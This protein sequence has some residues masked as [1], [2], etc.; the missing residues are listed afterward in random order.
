MLAL[1]GLA[2]AGLGE[3]T[4]AGPEG[5]ILLTLAIDPQT[6]KVLYAGTLA[7]GAFKGTTGATFWTPINTGLQTSSV[8]AVIIDAQT[9]TTL[10]LANG[11]VG[12]FKSAD[13]GASWHPVNTGLT[14][15]S[16]LG[17]AVTCG[18]TSGPVTRGATSVAVRTQ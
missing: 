12:V 13:G 3:W 18:T 9:S 15:L 11:G 10:Y 1:L 7:G 16:I 2:H 17:L 14:K 4:N 6:P 5:G 8:R